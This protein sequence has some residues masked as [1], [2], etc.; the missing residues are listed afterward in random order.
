MKKFTRDRVVPLYGKKLENRAIVTG[1]VRA[2]TQ[3]TDCSR[4]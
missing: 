4:C 1:A 2:R 3:R